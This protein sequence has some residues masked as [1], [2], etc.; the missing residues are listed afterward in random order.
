MLL[1]VTF[2]G[3][4]GDYNIRHTNHPPPERGHTMSNTIDMNEYKATERANARMMDTTIWEACKILGVDVNNCRT[5]EV[6]HKLFLLY[7]GEERA[8]N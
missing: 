7:L 4:G 3:C 2:V 6:F 8:N 1:I 5:S